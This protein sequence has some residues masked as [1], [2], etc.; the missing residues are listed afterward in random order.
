YSYASP[1]GGGYGQASRYVRYFQSRRSLLIWKVFGQRLDGWHNDDFAYETVPG[2]ANS[3]QYKGKPIALPKRSGTRIEGPAVNLA[4]IG[5]IMPPPEAV[6]GTYKTRDGHVIKVA[7]LTDEDR[8]TLARW[9]DLGCP[10]DLDDTGSKGE[11]R[12]ASWFAD[13]VRPTLTVSSPA[14]GANAK[15]IFLGM[16]DYESGLDLSSLHVTA[17]FAVNGTA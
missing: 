2:D 11:R 16:H 15:V 14:G 10:I 17:N 7:P 8:L 6:A 13:D 12:A 1:G 5:S 9:I 4:Y 3:L